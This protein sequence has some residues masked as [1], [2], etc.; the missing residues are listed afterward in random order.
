[1]KRSN[2]FTWRTLW[3]AFLVG[4]VLFLAFY[5]LEGFPSVGFDEGVHLLVAKRLALEGK[6][7]FG[8]ALGPTVFFPVAGVLRVLGVS[9]AAARIAMTG[10]L[11]LCV[12]ALYAI[13]R[14]SPV[15]L[16]DMRWLNI[17]PVVGPG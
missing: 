12:S 5:N 1:M 17:Q 13:A 6:Y 4:A 8:P 3:T 14:P 9:L 15:Q 11:L 16:G 2:L 10:Y 7:R